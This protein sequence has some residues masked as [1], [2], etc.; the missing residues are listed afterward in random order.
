MTY[1]ESNKGQNDIY[2]VFCTLE[3]SFKV[4]KRDLWRRK[5]RLQKKSNYF[6]YLSGMKWKQE[7]KVRIPLSPKASKVH[8][9]LCFSFCEKTFNF[10]SLFEPLYLF[11]HLF[12]IHVAASWYTHPCELRSSSVSNRRYSKTLWIKYMEY[13]EELEMKGLLSR[14]V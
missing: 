6:N 3:K 1:G 12:D 14:N 9:T 10:S 13:Q 7:M 4:S 5:T 11:V 8:F 2:L